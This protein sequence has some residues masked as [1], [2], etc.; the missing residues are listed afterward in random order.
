MVTTPL[1][2]YNKLNLVLNENPP[3]YAI[4]PSAENIYN[5][6]LNTRVVNAPEFLGIE[7]DHKSE[8]IYF[9]VDRY[10]DYIDL[11]TTSCTITYVNARKESR[12]YNVPF[13]DIYTY[14]SEGKMLIPWCLDATVAA[15]AGNV[16]FAIQF[17]KIG[18]RIN[19]DG[20][21]EKVLTYNLNTL[22]AMSQIKEGMEISKLDSSYLLT[23]SQA[24]ILQKQI[25]E[26]EVL[27]DVYWTVLTD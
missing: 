25:D 14:A 11:A 22:P 18:E 12:V 13:Y 7:R 10:S 27:Q 26:I 4:L 1:E 23:A 6:D 21:S 19:P 9:I 16:S 5:I 8:T 2:Y 20:I 24:Q 17:Y 3:A 15:A